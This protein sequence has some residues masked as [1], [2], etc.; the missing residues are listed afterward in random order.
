MVLDAGGTRVDR[1]VHNMHN[2]SH[3]YEY[4]VIQL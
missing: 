4:Y 1:A 2:N 3:K